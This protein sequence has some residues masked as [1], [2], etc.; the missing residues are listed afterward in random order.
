M[1]KPKDE[2]KFQSGL[3]VFK[4]RLSKPRSFWRLLWAE[5]FIYIAKIYRI[6]IANEHSKKEESFW[7][8]LS[9]IVINLSCWRSKSSIDVGR[10]ASEIHFEW[11][12]NNDDQIKKY[13][14]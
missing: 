9:N 5:I 1:L 14:Y 7:R 11:S 2:L 10:K 8:A 3:R 4:G 6:S 12:D 13:A